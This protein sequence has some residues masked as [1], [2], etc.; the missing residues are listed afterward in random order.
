MQNRFMQVD[1]E[2]Q[3]NSVTEV[4]P[5]GYVDDYYHDR[6]SN[7]SPGEINNIYST[8]HQI[9]EQGN[10]PE[11]EVG[12]GA[13][14]E[15]NGSSWGQGRLNNSHR[16]HLTCLKRKGDDRD[17]GDDDDEN[18]SIFKKSKACY[19]QSRLNVEIECDNSKITIAK[20]K[21]IRINI[22]PRLFPMT[23]APRE[24]LNI[25]LTFSC[26]FALKQ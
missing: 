2:E 3:L 26:L 22:F 13:Q 15:L 23:M 6:A 14:E 16:S 20:S 5:D 4:K 8:I 24:S 7:L 25:K 18:E 21:Q 10:Q 9:C 17:D 12:M 1:L 11:Y 19:V